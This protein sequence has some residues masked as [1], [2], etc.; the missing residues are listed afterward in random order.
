MTERIIKAVPIDWHVPT[1][2]FK[3]GDICWHTGINKKVEIISN[4]LMA[5]NR[6]TYNYKYHDGVGN[7]Q[8]S[9]CSENMLAP[10]SEYEEYNPDCQ[11]KINLVPPTPIKRLIELIAPSLPKGDEIRTRAA[12][13]AR[14]V[15]KERDSRGAFVSQTDFLNRINPKID[16]PHWG[17][18]S[19]HFDFELPSKIMPKEP[20]MQPNFDSDRSAGVMAD[21][22]D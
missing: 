15:I 11:I 17:A 7:V 8:K 3:L 16:F 9:S 4:P 10:Y 5:L 19:S 6:F 1:P 14:G 21:V 13:Y 2:K 18:I 22:E 12:T 20:L